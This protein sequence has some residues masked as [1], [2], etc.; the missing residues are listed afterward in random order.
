MVYDQGGVK[1]TA[2]EVD[3]QPVKPAFGYRVDFAGRSVV[4]RETRESPRTSRDM[5][6]GWIFDF[7]R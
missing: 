3:H 4:L 6:K 7:T 5:R 2:F 1:L